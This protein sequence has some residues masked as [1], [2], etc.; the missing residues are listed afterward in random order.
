MV[1]VVGHRGEW[2]TK[3]LID[4]APPTLDIE[5]VEQPEQHGTGDAAAVG[6]TGLPDRAHEDDEDGDVV[7]LPGD[8]P[9]LRPADPGRPGPAPPPPRRRGHPAHGRGRRPHRLRPGRAGA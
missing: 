3:T 6:L 4:H 9:L 2:V 8:T 5:F 7:V 1:V